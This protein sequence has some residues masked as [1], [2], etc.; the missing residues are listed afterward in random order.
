MKKVNFWIGIGASAVTLANL[1]AC[2]VVHFQGI[3]EMRALSYAFLAG[4]LVLSWLPYLLNIIFKMKFDLTISI[5]YQVFLILSMIVG[6]LWQVYGLWQPFDKVI[7]C[8]SGV[9]IALIAYDIFKNSKKQDISLVWIFILTFAVSM[10]CGGVWEIWEF[11]TDGLLGNN[12]QITAGLVGRE[13]IM[14]TMLDIVCDFVGGLV[15]GAIATVLE[16]Q[17]RKKLKE[18][19]DVDKNQTQNIAK[20]KDNKIQK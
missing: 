11:V 8:A 6:S 17:E 19:F 16:W 14:D 7:H 4:Y 1:I 5:C 2:L 9:L 20:T 13:A 3:R 10:M 12:A 18:N 15:G